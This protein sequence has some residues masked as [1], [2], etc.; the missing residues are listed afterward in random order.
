[1]SSNNDFGC[2]LTAASV[3]DILSRSNAEPYVI[4]SYQRPYRW[5]KEE[6]GRLLSD[7]CSYYVEDVKEINRNPSTKDSH[8]AKFVGT[9]I[10]VGEDGPST[11]IKNIESVIDG[12]QRLLTFSL[13]YLA[14][15]HS[16]LY[17]C[18]QLIELERNTHDKQINLIINDL[19]ESTLGTVTRCLW[20]N[21]NVRSLPN[22]GREGVDDWKD[23]VFKS[24]VPF[25]ALKL[26][27]S[28]RF[29]K[30]KYENIDTLHIPTE[31]YKFE[32][33]VDEVLDTINVFIELIL[34]GIK[35]DKLTQSAKE[36]LKSISLD[37]SEEDYP[38]YDQ[39]EKYSAARNF[40]SF[41]KNSNDLA[42]RH[43]LVGQAARLI[44]L[45]QFINSN[46]YIAKVTCR[47]DNYLDIF[48]SLNTAGRPLSPIETFIPEVYKFFSDNTKDENCL[49]TSPLIKVFDGDE[50]LDKDAN[51]NRTA[52]KELLKSIG[53]IL[54]NNNV[55]EKDVVNMVIS[56]ALIYDGKKCG[57]RAADQRQ[58]LKRLFIEN[59]VKEFKD[60]RALT[61]NDVD[62]IYQVVN[63]LQVLY[64]TVRWWSAFASHKDIDEITDVLADFLPYEEGCGADERLVNEARFALIVMRESNLTLAQTIACRFYIQYVLAEK[65]LKA[66]AYKEFLLVVRALLGFSAIWLSSVE[67]TTGI[68]ARF[69]ETITGKPHSN[70][71]SLCAKI[72]KS[73]PIKAA[74]VISRL[75]E[76]LIGK[77]GRKNI[78]NSEIWGQLISTS[79]MKRDTI[80][81]FMLLSYWRNSEPDPD[82]VGLRK[83]RRADN[84]KL[85]LYTVASWKKFASSQF[86]LEHIIPQ[87]ETEDWSSSTLGEGN[88]DRVVLQLGNLTLLPKSVNRF[89]KNSNWDTKALAYK[90]LT[91]QDP[92]NIEELW[93]RI[94]GFKSRKS[95]EAIIKSATE[96]TVTELAN[97]SLNW[98]PAFVASRSKRMAQL[99]WSQIAEKSIS[100]PCPFI[101]LSSSENQKST[102]LVPLN[103]ENLSKQS[104]PPSSTNTNSNE[105]QEQAH[106]SNSVVWPMNGFRSIIEAFSKEEN[107][108]QPDSYDKDSAEWLTKDG[109]GI[110]TVSRT[111]SAVRVECPTRSEVRVVRNFTPDIRKNGW[112]IFILKN[113]EDINN[114]MANLLTTVNRRIKYTDPD[115]LLA[116]S[117]QPNHVGIADEKPEETTGARISD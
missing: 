28:V 57:T 56:F 54:E 81:R 76:S 115:P 106:T 98:S 103:G 16:L 109:R 88:R 95:F 66:E 99:V 29:F 111:D 18:N 93:K 46:V 100:N 62:A 31:G 94:K 63:Y 21:N 25:L 60:S 3:L 108:G 102:A 89:I 53:T 35:E 52:V 85:E 24:P 22:V 82:A 97:S 44:S 41:S 36:K 58:M 48:E 86:D 75:R 42:K 30:N 7:I 83:P 17:L 79:I 19:Q 43:E 80:A 32:K 117:C 70:Q 87:T 2:Q 84:S 68:E 38:D 8:N 26:S 114:R 33:N 96:D 20:T 47:S 45:I 14:L 40:F 6:T 11:V 39:I 107:L 1:M 78:F 55:R 71:D 37:L 23:L 116:E 61:G 72:I 49:I 13:L 12:Q 113:K 112:N 110:L 67:S 74:E 104:S 10:V 105:S 15:T 92:T 4:P 59:A 65:E 9:I 73:N 51:S 50:T 34:I 90:A 64:H 5:G 101:E 77:F 27:D 69:R 91:A